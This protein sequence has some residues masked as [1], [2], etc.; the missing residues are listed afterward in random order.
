MDLE[1]LKQIGIKSSL[2]R[3][4]S[5]EI[6]TMEKEKPEYQI[7]VFH[8]R[9]NEKTEVKIQKDKVILTFLIPTDYPFKS[10]VILWNDKIY[11]NMLIWKT[12]YFQNVLQDNGIKCLCC[13]SLLCTGN[14]SPT[15]TIPRLIGEITKNKN[16]TLAI[17]RTRLVRQ[18]TASKGIHC[19][20]INELILNFLIEGT[21]PIVRPYAITSE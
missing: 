4:L 13:D 8:D 2:A 5:R 3:R 17:L 6:Q 15:I 9:I 1:Y 20:E 10:P 12:K 21:K 14:W 7:S 18:I 16:L 19:P 11:R